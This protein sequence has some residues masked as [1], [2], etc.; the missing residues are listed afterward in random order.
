MPLYKEFQEEQFRGVRYY[1]NFCHTKPFP[2]RTVCQQS[3]YTH[4]NSGKA[5]DSSPGLSSE[6]WR[7]WGEVTMKA[8][9]LHVAG[10]KHS[11]TRIC[12]NI[13]PEL[14]ILFHT[15]A[16]QSNWNLTGRSTEYP[17]SLMDWH[18]NC[19][20]HKNCRLSPG[21]D[22]LVDT[23]FSFILLFLTSFFLP[24]CLLH[25]LFPSSSTFPSFS[26]A[27]CICGNHTCLC[28]SSSPTHKFLL[29]ST[30]FHKTLR[31]FFLNVAPKTLAWSVDHWNKCQ[32]WWWWCQ[33]WWN[34][35]ISTIWS[36]RACTTVDLKWVPSWVIKPCFSWLLLDSAKG[37]LRQPSSKSNSSL[38]TFKCENWVKTPPRN[39]FLTTA[40]KHK[41][42]Y[43]K[44]FPHCP[45]PPVS[46]HNYCRRE[47]N[48]ELVYP[49]LRG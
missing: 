24:A 29:M 34:A 30:H 16:S 8:R 33:R 45:P 15:Y 42:P 41:K 9:S 3:N 38:R 40:L 5:P 49:L 36:H 32:N 26:K 2:T 19:C 11:S 31:F 18:G 37:D 48:L 4:C 21:M 1:I 28:A 46:C 35:G 12:R 6:L 17:A 25:F 47:G 20:L 22:H 43:F 39:F 23:A 10:Y 7:K 44:T 14:G 13:C 27:I